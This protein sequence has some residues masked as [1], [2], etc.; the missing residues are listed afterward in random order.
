MNE[1]QPGSI[2]CLEVLE[3][4]KNTVQ[5][6]LAKPDPHPKYLAVLIR[7]ERTDLRVAADLDHFMNEDNAVCL[8]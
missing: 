6:I 8:S 2:H 7:Q 5:C 1:R 4:G 3:L